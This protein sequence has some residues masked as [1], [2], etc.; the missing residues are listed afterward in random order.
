M[1]PVQPFLRL[2][3]ALPGLMW[4]LSST[5]AAAPLPAADNGGELLTLKPR[6]SSPVI[7]NGSS[8]DCPDADARGV[9]RP[10]DGDDDGVTQCDIGAFEFRPEI[11]FRNSFE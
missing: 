10:Q 2:S 3:A 5:A 1:I 8:A 7:D 6:P 9:P 11:L 4:L